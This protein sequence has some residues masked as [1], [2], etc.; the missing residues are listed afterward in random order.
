MWVSYLYLS[1][2]RKVTKARGLFSCSKLSV[3]CLLTSSKLEMLHG[4]VSR[5]PPNNFA[6]TSFSH[7]WSHKF[8]C[9]CS[10]T[11]QLFF[12][13]MK[14]LN[15]DPPITLLSCFSCTWCSA[16]GLIHLP[17]LFSVRFFV[18]EICLSY[19]LVIV[20]EIRAFLSFNNLAFPLVS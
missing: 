9:S 3:Q 17:V 1:K 11:L 15:K 20:K 8:L 13:I 14:Y 19:M 7:L 16:H 6:F 2:I 10:I 18:A 5:L 12:I 4:F